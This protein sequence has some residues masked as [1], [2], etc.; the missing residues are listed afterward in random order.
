MKVADTGDISNNYRD[1]CNDWADVKANNIKPI[2]FFMW[3]AARL[4]PNARL[5]ASDFW[6]ALVTGA[7]KHNSINQDGPIPNCPVMV[8]RCL[9]AFLLG[10][11]T[12]ATFRWLTVDIAGTHWYTNRP[13]ICTVPTAVQFYQMTIWHLALSDWMELCV[14]QTEMRTLDQ[15]DLG[16]GPFFEHV[17]T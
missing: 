1:W 15:A 12:H 3:A 16:D 13:T 7:I 17:A 4:A 8:V 10:R 6:F 2:Y 5:A 11:H 9:C 14:W